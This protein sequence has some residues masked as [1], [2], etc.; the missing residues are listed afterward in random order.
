M[1]DELPTEE[2]EQKRQFAIELLKQPTEPFKAAIIVFGDNTGRA[3][4]VSAR[5][6]HDPE[7]Q[8]FMQQAVE[9]MGDMHFLP[10]KA[11]LA[12]HAF[13]I[14]RDP[15]VHVED[16]LKAMR[17]YADIRGFIDKQGTVINNNVLTSNKVMLV[18]DHGSNEAWE[19]AAL[20][21]QQKLL[22]E[23]TTPRQH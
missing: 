6:P 7:V 15:K 10:S 23:A 9:D 22:D 4:E 1:T 21:Q 14:G 2:Q 18:A 13:E 16:R 20:Q 11:E 5:W 19:Q 3:L 12:R 8:T 17:L